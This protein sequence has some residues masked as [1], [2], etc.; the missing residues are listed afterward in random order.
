[1]L[2][3]DLISRSVF[4]LPVKSILVFKGEHGQGGL[5]TWE[6]E[7]GTDRLWLHLQSVVKSL[8]E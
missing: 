4:L 5:K 7:G 1:M 2:D 6:Q 8:A 3:V